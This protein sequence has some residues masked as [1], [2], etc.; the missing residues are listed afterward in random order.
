M[1][2]EIQLFPHN[3]RAYKRLESMLSGCDRACVV[4]PTGTGKFVIIAKLVQEHPLARF[5][6]V[7]TNE[8]MFND[9]LDNLS[10]IAPGFVPDNLKFVTYSRLMNAFRND[11][12]GHRC[13]YIILD[14]FHHCGAAEWGKGVQWLMD[15]NPN[16]KVVGFSATPI[17]Y[18]DG[19]RDMSDELFEGNVACSME[20]EEA[21]L[22]GILPIPKYI[23]ALYDAPRELGE[24][25]MSID[26]ITDKDKRADFEKR[27]EELRR[28]LQDAGGVDDVIARHLLDP[29]SKIVVFCPSVKMLEEFMSLAGTWFGK[30]TDS[31]RTY[32]TINSDPSAAVD[33]HSFKADEDPGLKILYCIN[34]LNEAVHI[35]G[36][37]AIVMVRPTR[38]PI[39]FH[40]QLGRVLSCG[41]N[42]TPLVF[43]LCNNFGS[44]GGISGMQERLDRAHRNL[45]ESG[46]ASVREPKDFEVIDAIKDPRVLAEELRE[47]L[48]PTMSIDDK[49]AF[50]EE[51]AA[52]NGGHL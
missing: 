18:S 8:Y 20:L 14:E 40:Q 42:K 25:R 16:A 33:F 32:R 6:L 36:I 13:D 23:V 51:I 48:N 49:I 10:R 27:Y 19:G 1:D 46:E 29:D 24:F 52:Q 47:A 28:S 50:L 43:D 12:S 22:R 39:V 44:L 38:S 37:D 5:L 21:W 41:C 31:I 34:Q 26:D 3:Q 7:G 45:R 35:D 15:R 30:V 2:S 11:A 17:R 9:Q 4:Q